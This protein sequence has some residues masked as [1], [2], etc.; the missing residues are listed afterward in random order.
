MKLIKET[1]YEMNAPNTIPNVDNE[2]SRFYKGEIDEFSI[3]FE[4]NDITIKSYA[5]HL[6]EMDL[7]N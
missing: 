3:L 5:M 4:M 7:K 2:L 1:V 6:I